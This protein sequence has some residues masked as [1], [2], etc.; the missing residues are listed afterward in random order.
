[1][2]RRLKRIA[3][4]EAQSFI[5]ASEF[6]AATWPISGFSIHQTCALIAPDGTFSWQIKNPTD[7]ELQTSQ[8]FIE[9]IFAQTR[10]PLR[11]GIPAL[12]RKLW[13]PALKREKAEV[14]HEGAAS[15]SAYLPFGMRHQRARAW[16]LAMLVSLLLVQIF[17]P[18]L[19]WP[20]SSW[21]Q[22]RQRQYY[23][24][25][26]EQL[27]LHEPI[28]V[29][30]LSSSRNIWLEERNNRFGENYFYQDGAYHMTGRD[31][32]RLMYAWTT[33]M[34]ADA[35]VEVAAAQI[36]SRWQRHR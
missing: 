18:F 28:F 20:A 6:G 32:D 4:R 30:D 26:G 24:T 14:P 34:I 16:L 35:A 31:P 33:E 13:R 36:E 1:L 21:L 27:Y 2:R 5:V 11:D 10:L 29:D 12:D 22:D 17:V 8:A 25:L 9:L 15:L 7:A 23:R 3:W 19:L